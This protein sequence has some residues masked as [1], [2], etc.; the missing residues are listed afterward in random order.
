M[1][2]SP[3]AQSP[4]L[5]AAPLPTDRESLKQAIISALTYRVGKDPATATQHDIY[6]AAA[7]VVRDRLVARCAMAMGLPV[8]GRDG[9]MRSRL[10]DSPLAGRGYVKTGTLDGVSLNMGVS[11]AA[12]YTASTRSMRAARSS[13]PA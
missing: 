12:R 8:I 5:A 1:T 7:L 13:L 2:S 11:P 6:Q 9:T 4:A 10:I 3:L